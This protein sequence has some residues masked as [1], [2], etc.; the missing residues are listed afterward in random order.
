MLKSDDAKSREVWAKRYG[1]ED[2]GRELQS[3]REEVV[4]GLTVTGRQVAWSRGGEWC[5]VVGSAGIV[6][7]FERWEGGRGR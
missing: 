6:G 3:H 4:K 7:V 2:A 5:V 1:I